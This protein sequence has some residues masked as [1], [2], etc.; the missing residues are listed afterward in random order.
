LAK[1]RLTSLCTGRTVLDGDCSEVGF[2]ATL[3]LPGLIGEIGPG[4]GPSLQLIKR[5]RMLFKAMAEKKRLNQ[6]QRGMTLLLKIDWFVLKFQ[7]V[8]S[9]MFCPRTAMLRRVMMV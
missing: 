1:E 3:L 9:V 5:S 7:S 2:G 4:T 6:L 8:P